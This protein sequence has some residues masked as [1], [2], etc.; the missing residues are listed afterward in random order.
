MSDTP[1]TA[2]APKA[3]APLPLTPCD[4][5]SIV[6]PESQ[7]K[8]ERKTRDALSV[9]GKPKLTT[10]TREAQRLAWLVIQFEREGMSQA[11]FCRRT[12]IHA[13]YLNAIRNMET[14]GARGIGASIV[15]QVRDGLRV[16]PNYFFDDYE[17][18]RPYKMYLLTAIRDEKRVSAIEDEM[19]KMRRDL[20]GV[21]QSLAENATLKAR[22]YDLE[23]ENARLTRE[24]KSKTSARKS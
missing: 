5:F 9:A 20:A 21:Q 3:P 11:E 15:R 14:A 7:P 10:P 1:V 16:H 18:E 24:A 19:A 23:L 17:G 8:R 6:N 2:L 22:L 4:T 13:P 12:G